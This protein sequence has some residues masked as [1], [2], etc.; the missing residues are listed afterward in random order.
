MSMS[1]YLQTAVAAIILAPVAY[2]AYQ[3]YNRL[4]NYLDSTP[5]GDF[6]IVSTLVAIIAFL[7]VLHLFEKLAWYLAAQKK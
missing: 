3:I 4:P 7:S 6:P 1:H 2:G 5:L